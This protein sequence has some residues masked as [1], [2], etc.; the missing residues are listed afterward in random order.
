VELVAKQHVQKKSYNVLQ[1]FTVFPMKH[2]LMRCSVGLLVAAAPLTNLPTT[3]QPA[4]AQS[5]ASKQVLQ[6]PLLRGVNLT[7]Q[8]QKKLI[9]IRQ[10]TDQQVSKLLTPEQKKVAA[11]QGPRA[12]QLTTAQQTQ[13]I[14]IARASSTRVQAIFTPAQIQKIKANIQAMQ[15]SNGQK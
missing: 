15:N 3:I 2:F 11:T 6:S 8:Q 12:V 4:A 9:Q 13:Y 1:I 14:K 10:E 7:P 5:T